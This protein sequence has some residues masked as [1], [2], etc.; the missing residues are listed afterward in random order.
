MALKS[1]L[2]PMSGT[3][4]DRSALDLALTLARPSAAH[5][6][7]VY[8]RRDPREAIIYAS[9]GAGADGLAVGPV[10]DELEREGREAGERARRMMEAWRAEAGVAAAVKPDPYEHVTAGWREQIGS[11]DQTVMQAAARADLVVCAGLQRPP[12]LEQ[13]FIE[14]ALF[15]AA[16]PV[17]VAPARIAGASFHC[18][19]LAWNGSH[20]ANRAAAAALAWLPR[21]D[22]FYV[23]CQ[24]ESHRAP[25]FPVDAVELLA[26][27]GV[28]AEILSFGPPTKSVG[29]DLLKALASVEASFLIMGAYTHGRTRQMM[30][31]GATHHVLHHAT[32][33]VLLVH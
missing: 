22:R 10:M 26:W 29:I 30:F 28:K 8:P 5:V 32:L 2:V 16:R 20:E 33:P 18:A 14:A 12:G 3:P 4:T 13:D 24:A 31:G 19:V 25:A 23:F 15:G 7:A 21:F 27:H 1:I 17:V 9:M 6:E 11:P